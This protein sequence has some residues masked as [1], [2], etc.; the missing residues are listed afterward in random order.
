MAVGDPGNEQAEGDALGPAGQEA[1]RGKAVQHRILGWADLLD[2]E[3]VVHEREAGASAFFG[4]PGGGGQHSRQRPRLSGKGEVRE[5]HA[6]LH[7]G[8]LM[9]AVVH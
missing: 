3:Q 2:L 7:G 9:D 8:H 6:D 1:E 4:R 5:V